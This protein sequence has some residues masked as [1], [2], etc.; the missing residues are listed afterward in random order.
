MSKNDANTVVLEAQEAPVTALEPKK[1][2]EDSN[3]ESSGGDAMSGAL[4]RSDSETVNDTEY[5]YTSETLT[6]THSYADHWNPETREI[7]KLSN[8]NATTTY[9]STTSG[10]YTQGHY[11][12][13]APVTKNVGTTP[14]FTELVA[15]NEDAALV[16]RMKGT[17]EKP[18]VIN[19]VIQDRI[20]IDGA[21][22]EEDV[23]QCSIGD[24]YFLA[25]VL[26][27][28]RHDPSVIS[29]MMRVSGTTVTTSFYHKEKTTKKNWLGIKKEVEKWVKQD[30]SVQVGVLKQN[31]KYKGSHFRVD[32]KPENSVWS[33]S[34]DS[35]ILKI[36][37]E[38]LFEAASWL[39]CMEQAYMIFAQQYGPYGFGD[40]EG[41]NLVDGID[42]G[43]AQNCMY[44]FFGDKVDAD[45][46][47]KIDV[48]NDDPEADIIKKNK[49]VINVLLDYAKQQDGNGKKDVY[50]MAGISTTEAVKQLGIYSEAAA[51]ELRPLVG[52]N[53]QLSQALSDIETIHDKISHYYDIADEPGR[54]GESG[55]W[56]KSIRDDIDALSLSLHNNT[57]FTN[58]NLASYQTLRESIGIVVAK[59]TGKKENYNNIFIYSGHA[60]SVDRLSL[61]DKKG[62]DLTKGLHL[63]A[64][65]KV[66]ADLSRVTL[67]N[68][69]AKTKPAM[70]EAEERFNDGKFTISL[71]SF[72]NNVGYIRTAVVDKD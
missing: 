67:I 44:M 72:L 4:T 36:T 71:R 24:C 69:H 62:N 42:G 18:N 1:D 39:I 3:A 16:T 40:P 37:R 33:S 15:T 27:V 6:A 30:I 68:P 5:T 28:I 11:V 66:D 34:V 21:P 17:L 7:E 13:K 64:A 47:E 70:N 57:E 14:S 61:V 20:Y 53:E 41:T 65:S 55:A 2:N 22:V 8:Y 9:L 43:H 63:F 23:R 32:Y 59:V 60:Y 26:Q 48:E 31:N 19:S 50:L 54:E 52:S 12:A 56:Q 46:V 35:S 38:D 51:N 29:N 10:T 49:A 45:S 58:L 25:S